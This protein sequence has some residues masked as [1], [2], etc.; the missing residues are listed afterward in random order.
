[1][2][3]TTDPRTQQFWEVV[4]VCCLLSVAHQ[5]ALFSGLF[6]AEIKSGGSPV[7][8]FSVLPISAV[9]TALALKMLGK[10]HWG[11]VILAGLLSLLLTFMLYVIF[12]LIVLGGISI[13]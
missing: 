8:I 5:F 2:M 3:Q 10:W 9:A 4:L 7:R 6:S 11:Q 13:A 12:A 1:M